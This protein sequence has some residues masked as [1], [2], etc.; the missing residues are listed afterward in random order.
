MAKDILWATI[1]ALA[2]VALLF[3]LAVMVPIP[4]LGRAF[5]DLGAPLAEILIRVIPISL[6][7]AFSP[8]RGLAA[9]AIVFGISSIIALFV[10]L[11]I[12]AFMVLR[13][14]ARPNREEV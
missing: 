9:S 1:I 14:R 11:F 6:I 3:T 7:N 13:W 8:Q 5:A 4:A 12:A 10:V 2:G